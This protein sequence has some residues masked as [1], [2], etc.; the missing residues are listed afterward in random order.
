MVII[1]SL[2]INFMYKIP[3]WPPINYTIN[4]LYKYFSVIADFLVV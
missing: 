1:A 2:L 4:A 3:H